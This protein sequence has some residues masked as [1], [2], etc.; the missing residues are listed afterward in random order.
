MAMSYKILSIHGIDIELHLF[1]IIFVLAFLVIDPFL[2]L[3]L[4]IIFAFVAV[5]ELSHSLVAV[6]QGI[7]V[8][9][10]ILLPIGGV[11][12]METIDIDPIKEIKMAVAG[13]LFNFA[14]VYVMIIISILFSLPVGDWTAAFLAGQE[15]PLLPMLYFYGTVDDYTWWYDEQIFE[16]LDLVRARWGPNAD[17][18]IYTGCDRWVEGANSLT[19][20]LLQAGPP[21]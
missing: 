3:F 9:K 17:L 2:S 11:A 10:I 8:K 5:H 4:V 16:A 12:M 20:L 14:V 21:W 19:Q 15:L 6:R 18:T 13:P 1:F 7:K